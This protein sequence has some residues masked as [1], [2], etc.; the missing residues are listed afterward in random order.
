M[1]IRILHF[2]LLVGILLAFTRKTNIIL[3]ASREVHSRVNDLFTKPVVGAIIR[4]SRCLGLQECFFEHSV[5]FWVD[6]FSNPLST[7]APAFVLSTFAA[8]ASCP[9][10]ASAAGTLT[11]TTMKVALPGPV[12]GLQAQFALV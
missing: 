7:F 8:P 11:S 1:F 3:I 12:A 4:A 6:V 10:A 2:K 5:E 9:L